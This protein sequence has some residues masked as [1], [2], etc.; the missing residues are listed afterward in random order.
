VSE[1]A[2]DLPRDEWDSQNAVVP[3]HE[4]LNLLEGF[5]I[6]KGKTRFSLVSDKRLVTDR[7]L[8]YND[9]GEG[10]FKYRVKGVQMVEVG[11]E[12][13]GVYILEILSAELT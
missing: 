7:E 6:A 13:V 11:G 5:P 3:I 10:N 12:L 8:K 1:P 2:E 9:F 4:Q